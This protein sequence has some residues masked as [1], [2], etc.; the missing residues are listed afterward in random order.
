[1][2]KETMCISVQEMAK[3]LGI[4]NTSAYK[5]I[6][7]KSFYPAK[8]VCG[9]IVVNLEELKKWIKGQQS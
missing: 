7:D 5:L 9:R 3:Q 1:M 8:R 6:S 4:G 2:E